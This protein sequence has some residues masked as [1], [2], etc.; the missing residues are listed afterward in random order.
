MSRASNTDARQSE[1]VE[2]LLQV[3]AERGYAGASVTRIAAQ[4]GLAAGLVHYHFPN[5]EAILLALV[6]ALA[7][8]FEAR[9]RARLDGTAW[10]DLHAFVDALLA[11]G[12]GADPAAARCWV[13]VGAVALQRPAVAARYRAVVAAQAE[14]LA[15]RI[16]AV[17]DHEGWGGDAQAMAATV[18]ATAAGAFHLAATA[19]GVMAPGS[20]APLTRHMVR[21]L[22]AGVWP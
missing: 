16:Q 10:G 22:L 3:M 15:A 9:E 18:L 4:A 6:D 1:I 14:R 19:P 13:Q 20:A 21:G 11:T 12:E 7:A 8:R 2:A 5:K 17:L